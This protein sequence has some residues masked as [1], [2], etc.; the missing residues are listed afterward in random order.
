VSDPEVLAGLGHN[1]HVE[2]PASV[3]PLLG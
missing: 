2:Q 3:L 1:A